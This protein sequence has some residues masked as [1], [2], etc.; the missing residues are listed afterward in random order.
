[1]TTVGY[2]AHPETLKHRPCRSHAVNVQCLREH[3]RQLGASPD[4]KERSIALLEKCLMEYGIGKDD[5][6]LL[7]SHFGNFGITGINSLM[8]EDMRRGA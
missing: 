3:A 7:S 2:L 5:A 6:S 4:V 1:M 8:P